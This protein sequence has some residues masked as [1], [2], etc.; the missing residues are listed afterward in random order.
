MQVGGERLLIIPAALGYGKSG[1]D[2]IPGNSTLHFGEKTAL[3]PACRLLTSLC[4]G[5]AH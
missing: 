1:T 3:S 5:E 4:R 2:G